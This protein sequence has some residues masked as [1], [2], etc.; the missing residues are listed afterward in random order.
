MDGAY[1]PCILVCCADDR[2]EP[3][4]ALS[5]MRVPWRAVEHCGW[6]EWLPNRSASWGRA[7]RDEDTSAV[8]GSVHRPAQLQ[9]A[10]WNS[11]SVGSRDGRTMADIFNCGTHDS[12]AGCSVMVGPRFGDLASIF[13][14]PAADQHVGAYRWARRFRGRF[15]ILTWTSIRE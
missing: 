2:R 11:I 13:P 10:I 14:L 1:V 3:H 12:F 6:T 9:T 5:C 8:G 15:R 7:G 4:R